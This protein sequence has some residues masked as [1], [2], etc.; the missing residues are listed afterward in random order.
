MGLAFFITLLGLYIKRVRVKGFNVLGTQYGI[1]V[2]RN[3]KIENYLWNSFTGKHEI[4]REEKGFIY[5]LKE[6]KSV[7]N[8]YGS[9]K[10]NKHLNFVGINDYEFYLKIFNHRISDKTP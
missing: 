4:I 5:E 10:T 6:F 2:Y 7:Y 3:N 8:K 9:N 1:Y